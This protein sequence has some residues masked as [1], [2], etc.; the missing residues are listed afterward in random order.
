[1][2]ADSSPEAYHLAI[3]VSAICESSRQAII[4]RA[5]AVDLKRLSASGFATCLSRGI[6]FVFQTR[7][8]GRGKTKTISTRSG[9][10]SNSPLRLTA[11]A[12]IAA[13]YALTGWFPGV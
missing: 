8:F 9:P 3:V 2:C 7:D 6:A 1:T 5:S 10:V 11:A 4:L 12:L 13:L